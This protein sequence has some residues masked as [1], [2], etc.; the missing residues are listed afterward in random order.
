M[1]VGDVKKLL[2][3]FCLGVLIWLLLTAGM[4]NAMTAL[5]DQH[6]KQAVQELYE[7]YKTSFPGV[8]EV[9]PEEA[10][11]LQQ[12]GQ[13]VFVDVRPLVERRVS[14]LPGAI[15]ASD[16]L[17]NPDMF[18]GRTLIAYDT[19][20]YRSGLFAEQMRR[21]GI[22]L[23]NLQ[24]GLLGWLYAGGKIFDNEG[25]ETRRLHIYGCMWNCAPVGYECV[26]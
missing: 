13:A 8:P 12:A 11:K 24:G 22:D 15:A 16:F 19:L 3:G 1:A 10:I 2:P 5:Q 23:A 20:G 18:Q 26:R 17:K 6:R 21:K 9:T 25:R 7:K 14:T 4:S